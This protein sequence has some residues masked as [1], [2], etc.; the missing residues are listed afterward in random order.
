MCESIAC[1][2]MRC[3]GHTREALAMALGRYANAWPAGPEPTVLVAAEIRMGTLHG[4]AAL[5][6]QWSRTAESDTDRQRA[7]AYAAA[8][9][10]RLDAIR[11][12]RAG[13]GGAGAVLTPDE[14]AQYDAAGRDAELS[15]TRAQRFDDL[16]DSAFW[17]GDEASA[18]RHQW[19]AA[20][21]RESAAL[22]RQEQSGL[23]AAAKARTGRATPC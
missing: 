15:E 12:A 11:T 2:G 13:V 8:A 3:A 10:D 19:M 18:G 5:A 4:H 21:C 9:Q 22:A 6:R 7:Q 14:R 17:D 20:R 1:G 23:L 16:A